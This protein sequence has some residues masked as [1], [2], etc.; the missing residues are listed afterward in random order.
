MGMCLV[1]GRKIEKTEINGFH[2]TDC[3]LDNVYLE[4]IIEYECQGCGR[5]RLKIPDIKALHFLIAVILVFKMEPLT[6]HEIGY[7]IEIIQRKNWRTVN[8]FFDDFWQSGP[9]IFR[10]TGGEWRYLQG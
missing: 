1:C 6:Y 4:R 9:M 5:R 8:C 10:W 2:Y 7:L 3:G